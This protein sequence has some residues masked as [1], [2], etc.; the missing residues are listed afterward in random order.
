MIKKNVEKQALKLIDDYL[1]TDLENKEL[2]LHI[3][4]IISEWKA[5]TGPYHNEVSPVYLK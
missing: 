4:N 2:V 5:L 3:S 1:D